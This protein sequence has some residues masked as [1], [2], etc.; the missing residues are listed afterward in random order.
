[1]N[2]AN[3]AEAEA[4]QKLKKLTFPPRSNKKMLL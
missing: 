3:R 1:M 4:E 2:N